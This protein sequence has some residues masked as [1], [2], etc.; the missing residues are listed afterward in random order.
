VAHRR[1]STIVE[2]MRAFEPTSPLA[3]DQFS[4]WHCNLTP[5][6]G[7][8]DRLRAIIRGAP[9]DGFLHAVSLGHRGCG[10]ST[11]LLR[12]A[13]E[14]SDGFFVVYFPVTN[15]LDVNDLAFSD[16]YIAIAMVVVKAFDDA[17]MSLPDGLLQPILD[18][19]STVVE[20][21]TKESGG[22]VTTSAEAQAGGALA[23]I[24]KL[25]AG[26]T[27]QYK[28]STG[29]KRSIRRVIERDITRLIN[30]TNRLL[31]GARKLLAR[32]AGGKRDLLIIV[33]NID[34]VPADVGNRLVFE[35]G[36]FLRQLRAKVLW[37]MPVSLLYSPRPLATSFPDHDILPMVKVF[38]RDDPEPH[39]GWDEDCVGVLAEVIAKRANV[40]AVFEDSD[41]PSEL[42]RYSGGCVRDLLVLARW[43]AV[44][45]SASSAAKIS[46]DH[47]RTAA[48][49]MR[50]DFER[51]IPWDRYPMLREVAA[52]KKVPNAPEGQDALHYPYALEYNGATRWN[53]VHPLV[54]EIEQ[55]K[56]ATDG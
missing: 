56:S 43:A 13:D 16:L 50:S 21:S 37:T 53:Y 54:R 29:H 4:A 49:R 18:F 38:V 39:L 12:L 10:K 47:V 40:N 7:G 46:R 17:G 24:A 45:A 31:D 2:A 35:H 8:V 41:L 32:Q 44:E 27:S 15:Y 26:I 52:T 25:T 11:E 19:A 5:A 6:R 48:L 1:A 9:A 22:A 42:A 34:R 33:D 23:F 20:E 14:L 36:D 51:S 30:D 3:K 28:A 55:F